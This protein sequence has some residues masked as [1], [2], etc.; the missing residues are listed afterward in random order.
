M[1]QANRQAFRM[2]HIYKFK[3][4]NYISEYDYDLCEKDSDDEYSDAEENAKSSQEDHK[5][6]EDDNEEVD[7][8]EETNT[9]SSRPSQQRPSITGASNTAASGKI[10]KLPKSIT[11]MLD[12]FS[13]KLAKNKSF[14]TKLSSNKLL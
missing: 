10:G 4:E 9:R 12:G 1:R 8:E 7:E 3:N 14:H 6:E 5:E 11:S 2:E 13:L